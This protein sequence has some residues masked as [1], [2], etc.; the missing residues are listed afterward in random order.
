MTASLGTLPAALF[1]PALGEAF[2]LRGPDG[3]TLAV[4]LARCD[5]Y[6]R[7]TMPGSA[8]TAFGLIFTCPVEAAG[9]HPGGDGVLS[10]PALGE[11]GP[12]HVARILPIGLPPGTAAFEA[13]FT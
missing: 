6:P 1:A 5:E 3:H 4:T 10:H 13:S 2:T 11:F 12:L 9:D 7:A 8:R